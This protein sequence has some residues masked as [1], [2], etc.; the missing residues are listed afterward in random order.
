LLGRLFGSTGT[1]RDKS[2]IVLSITPHIIRAQSRPTSES[3]E[4]WYGTETQTRSAPF[5]STPA[6]ES[7]GPAASVAPGGVS[8]GSGGAAA[9]PTSAMRAAPTRLDASASA[10]AP[11][12]PPV[13]APQPAPTGPVAGASQA[14]AN[15]AVANSTTAVVQPD[16]KKSGAGGEGISTPAASPAPESDSPPKVSIEGPDTAKVGDEINV[17]VR[18]ASG[19]APG[20]LRT[21]VRFDAT[22]LQLVSA[23]PGDLASSGD[24]PKVE[25]RPGGVQL[26]L[27]GTSGARLGTAGSIVNL[28]F[29]AVAPR[30]AMLVS[31]QV[32]MLGEDGAAMAAT[33]ATPLKI[34]ITP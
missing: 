10:P 7:T 19:A 21:Q 29:R 24:A 27:V 12:A 4:F 22:A 14:G 33:P 20:R 31:T 15:P 23:E 6:M 2:E 8:Y 28:K 17:A 25:V 3:M 34:A 5:S 30:P 32:V 18:L 13:V 1:T 26:E 16:T 11:S 9:A